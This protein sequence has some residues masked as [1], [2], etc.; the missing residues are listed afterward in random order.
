[1]PMAVDD[2]VEP[3]FAICAPPPTPSAALMLTLT[4]EA[5]TSALPCTSMVPLL[6]IVS[7]PALPSMPFTIVVALA[8]VSA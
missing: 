8:L 6:P 2:A 4:L 1:M 7:L 3:A 5:A